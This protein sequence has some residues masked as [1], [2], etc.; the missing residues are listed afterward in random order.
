M[1]WNVISAVY[2]RTSVWNHCIKKNHRVMPL[3][4]I[5]FGVNNFFWIKKCFIFQGGWKRKICVVFVALKMRLSRMFHNYC[6]MIPQSNWTL[7]RHAALRFVSLT[8][9]RLASSYRACSF[10]I[11]CVNMCRTR[12]S[13]PTLTDTS[14]L[15]N[16]MCECICLNYTI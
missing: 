1:Y 15:Y 10:T 5:N 4:G 9:R 8:Y 12:V 14:L 3:T 16:V 11:R 2:S 13:P 7:Y 6:L